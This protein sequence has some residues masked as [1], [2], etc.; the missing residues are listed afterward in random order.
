[1]EVWVLRE[2]RDEPIDTPSP[3][4]TQR[5]WEKRTIP[6]GR[7]VVGNRLNEGKVLGGG[8]DGFGKLDLGREE[9]KGGGDKEVI[10]L[11]YLA[12]LLKIVLRITR[13]LKLEWGVVCQSSL[14]LSLNSGDSAIH[15]GILYPGGVG[16]VE[17]V[18]KRERGR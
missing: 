14:T 4:S 11:T 16:G 3:E 6:Q 7:G 13:F 8:V 9:L 12:A 2:E 17:E 15:W 18:K 1:M 10:V 5:P